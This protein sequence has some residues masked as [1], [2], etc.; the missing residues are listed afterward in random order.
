MFLVIPGSLLLLA[1][2]LLLPVVSKAALLSG[3]C[4]VPSGSYP[5]LQ[6]AVSDGACVT[7]SVGA[8]VLTESVLITRSVS[9]VGQGAD[10]SILQGASVAGSASGNVV[11]IAPGSTVQI[12]GLA[13]RHG[14]GA[15]FNQG[16]I[17]LTQSAIYSNVTSVTTF[18]NDGTA[19]IIQSSIHSN[20]VTA[21]GGGGILNNLGPLLIINSTVSG[22]S[23]T[24]AGGG[25]LN[26]NDAILT[27]VHTTVANNL[28]GVGGGGLENQGHVT[29][30]N[31]ILLNNTSGAGGLGNCS[32]NQFGQSFVT[33]G[34]NLYADPSD[35][36]FDG[37]DVMS[38]DPSSEIFLNL[39]A[40]G[41]PTLSHDLPE[42]SQA[43]DAAL[44]CTDT[45]GI[46]V[47]VDQR[48]SI[49]PK[50]G[51]TG[52]L[53]CD[54]GA[55]EIAEAFNLYIPLARNRFPDCFYLTKE[56]EP[57]DSVA[58]ANGP[59][60]RMGT[61]T[62]TP[63]DTDDYFSFETGDFG[64]IQIML[65][66]HPLG[67]EQGAQIFLYYETTSNQVAFDISHPYAINYDGAAGLYIFRVFTDQ[68]KCTE[69]I[70]DSDYSIDFVFPDPPW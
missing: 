45:N 53:R 39:I 51:G 44:D 69:N 40:G 16:H 7:I 70:C 20:T 37:G 25:I 38:S 65:D 28:S 58:Q 13:I 14:N 50:D 56:Q 67:P 26:D 23:V 68:T 32:S 60:C 12:S 62:G 57:N 1:M 47:T 29:I 63:D 43:I 17:T 3:A 24:S 55:V 22:N 59:L 8:T 27:L 33:D 64:S 42:G 36:P 11:T 10:A 4:N 18:F 35:C 15:I 48:D 61:Y 52:Q 46:V 9:I 31:S 2:M 6:G 41:G 5:S 66:G 30:K 49:R 19:A 34:K 21:S 54:L